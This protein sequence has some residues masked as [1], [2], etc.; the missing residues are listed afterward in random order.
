M[1]ADLRSELD[2]IWDKLAAIEKGQAGM[3]TRMGIAEDARATAARQMI[4]LAADIKQINATLSSIAITL[5]TARGGLWVGRALALAVAGL[6]GWAS[7]YVHL[8]LR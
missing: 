1:D 8:G 6:V 2:K 3:E 4:A 5:A 7:N